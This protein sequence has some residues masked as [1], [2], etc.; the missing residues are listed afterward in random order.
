MIRCS[1]R[2]PYEPTPEPDLCQPNPCGPNGIC[3]ASVAGSFVCSCAPGY[4]GTPCRPECI[5]PTDCP[6]N[7]D[8]RNQKC[9][10]PC[11]GTCGLD[12]ICSVIGH[13][14]ICR[15]RDG[16]TGDPF[17]RCYV[18][19]LPPVTKDD[20]CNPS[21]C[22]PNSQCRVES[23]R[24]VCTCLPN[25][26]GG[27]PNC[28]P[29]CVVNSQCSSSLACIN[30]KC[31][32]PCADT[33]GDR[34]QC[35]VQNHKAICTCPPYLTG[36]AYL[37]C[38]EIPVTRPP[39]VLPA[40]DPCSGNP[41]G[42][43]SRCQAYRS[44]RVCSCL[45][46]Y[47]GTPPQC[48]PEC[49]RAEE[50]SPT[51][52][53]LV[54][55]CVD[56]CPGICGVNAEC[57][58]VSHNPICSCI[59]GYT[60]DPFV[61]CTEIPPIALTPRPTTPVPPVPAFTKPTT[62]S[63][64]GEHKEIT[65]ETIIPGKISTTTSSPIAET[66]FLEEP[67]P[68]DPCDPSPCAA[69]AACAIGYDGK[70]TCECKEG[71]F[72][73]PFVICG[74][75]CVIDSDCDRGF[76]CIQRE[77]KDPCPGACGS[78]AVCTVAG[79]RP[80]CSCIPGFSGDPY[81]EC[82]IPPI[83]KTTTARPLQPITEIPRPC[84]PNPCGANAE[85]IPVG[86]GQC[87][88]IKGYFGNPYD[89]CQPEC[90]AD[91]H[92]PYNRECRNEKCVDPCP[93]TCGLKAV[94][95]VVTHK[96]MCTCTRGYSGDP[97]RECRIEPITTERPVD[98]CNPSP[99]GPNSHCQVSYTGGHD[100]TCLPDY[101]GSP[102]DCR[103]QCVVS[104]DCPNDKACIKQKCR[105]PCPGVCGV[106]ALCEVRDH[107]PICFCPKHLTGDPFTR[108]VP[109]K[110]PVISSTSRPPI[111][112]TPSQP[113]AI[114]PETTSSTSS[115]P[116]TRE[117]TDP[118][119]NNPC[120]ERAQCVPDGSYFDC[121]CPEGMYGN[122][123]TRCKPDCVIDTDCPRNQ[124][125][126]NERCVDPCMEACGSGASCL[127]IMH[128]PV[129]TCSFGLSGD[130]Y[131]ACRAITSTTPPP[132]SETSPPES[133]PSVTPQTKFCAR[134]SCG[135]NAICK[136]HSGEVICEC[137]PAYP[138]GDP[139]EACNPQ[140]RSNDD[141]SRVESC[142][143]G[144]C[145]DPC[146]GTCGLAA[147]CT[148][149]N[150]KALCDCPQGFTGSPYRQCLPITAPPDEKDDKPCSME[151]CG[152]H[153][154]CQEENLG[155]VCKCMSGFIGSPPNCKP[156]CLN[157]DDCSRNTACINHLCS[158]PCPNACG[159]AA[160]CE[161][162]GSS[163]RCFCPPGLTGNPL[164][165]CANITSPAV[166][167]PCQCG[168]NA[169]CEALNGHTKCTCYPG[170]FG[171]PYTGCEPECVIDQDCP[172]YLACRNNKCIDPCPGYCGISA[173]CDVINHTP[174]CTCPEGF[175]GDPLNRCVRAELSPPA[176]V[177]PCTPNPCG[178]YTLCQVSGSRPVCSCM[179]GYLG[180]P[181]AG[182]KP[183]CVDNSECPPH[184]A[185]INRQCADPCEGSCAPSAECKVNKHHPLCSC[186]PGYTG[187]PFTGCALAPVADIDPCNPD[188]CGINALCHV[189]GTTDY[190]CKCPPNY[191]GN[192]FIEC[193]PEC[194]ANS[195]C[196][197]YLQCIN[198]KCEDPCPGTCGFN[199]LCETVNHYPMCDCPRGLEGD[200]K[201]ACR[202]RVAAA[203]RPSPATDAPLSAVS[204]EYDYT[205]PT[206]PL[207]T[208]IYTLC[209]SNDNCP[210]S[211]TCVNRL[212]VDI[213]RAG[214]CGIEAECRTLASRPV[215]SCPP[216]TVGNPTVQCK[217]ISKEV[218][219]VPIAQTTDRPY[220]FEINP[221]R[222]STSMRPPPIV[223]ATTTH[224]SVPIYQ[225]PITPILPTIIIACEDNDECPSDNSCVNRNCYDVCSLGVCGE[226]AECA[227]Y[228][229]R[230]VCT[231][232]LGTTVPPI[233][234]ACENNDNCHEGMSCVNLLCYDACALGVCGDHALCVASQH[235]PVCICPPGTTGNPQI[236]CLALSTDVPPTFEPIAEMTTSKT[237][238]SVKPVKGS[239]DP[240]L[241]L[242]EESKYLEPVKE[243]Y[244]EFESP[245][246]PILTVGCKNNDDC[247][248]DKSCINKICSD[249]CSQSLCAREAEC[250]TVKRRPVCTCPTGTT[251]NP[252][253][254]C[255]AINTEKTTSILVETEPTLEIQ[256]NIIKPIKIDPTLPLPIPDLSI[257]TTEKMLENTVATPPEPL[258]SIA[259]E[260]NDG[261]ATDN[262]CI[263]RLCYDVCT[264][265]ICGN[266]AECTVYDHR[267]VC[268]CPPGTTGDPLHHCLAVTVEIN[269]VEPPLVGS[270]SRPLLPV[271]PI[272]VS[273][274]FPTPIGI[275]AHYEPHEP[276]TVEKTPTPPTPDL[277]AI[278]CTTNDDC[279][280]KDT[281]LNQLCMD[282]CYPGL[283]GQNADCVTHRHKPLCKCPPGTTGNPTLKCSAL[284]TD[285]PDD[286]HPPL[287]EIPSQ[288]PED[289]IIPQ[290]GTS[291][292][293]LPPIIEFPEPHLPL[294]TPIYVS[295]IPTPTI[296]IACTNN[297]NCRGTD[298]CIN[299]MCYDACA[300]GV[301]GVN[302]N[303]QVASHRPVCHCPPGTEG[304]PQISCS[305]T[306]SKTAVTVPPIS[307][308]TSIED[309]VIVPVQG[310]ASARPK[311]I[312]QSEISVLEEP[313]YTTPV[314]PIPPT[315]LVGCENN[316]DCPSDTSCMNFVC[317]NACAQDLCGQTATCST[318]NNLP[319]CSCPPGTTGNPTKK[320]FA[321]TTESS[322][323]EPPVADVFQEQK[324]IN[325]VPQKDSSTTLRPIAVTSRP[326]DKGFKQPSLL[327]PIIPPIPVFCENNDDC[328][329]D[330]SCINELCYDVCTLGICGEDSE[331]TVFNHRPVCVCPAGTSGDPLDRC[332]AIT[333]EKI[334]PLPPLSDQVTSIH[335]ENILPITE[336]SRLPPPIG[337]PSHPKP[338][339]PAKYDVPDITIE[340]E[341]IVIGCSVND[342]CPM[343]DTCINKFCMD[344]CHPDLCGYNAECITQHH[345]PTCECPPGTTGNPTV[346]CSALATDM[347]E[348]LLPPLSESSSKPIDAPV[349][350]LVGTSSST[351]PPIGEFPEQHL[352]SPEIPFHSPEISMPPIVIAC[353]NNDD[354]IGT[355]SCVNKMC[356]NACSLGICGVNADCQ[357]D[358]HRPVCHCPKGTK[359]HPQHGCY[360][361]VSNISVSLQPIVS[362]IKIEDKII[363]PIRGEV[364]P[365]PKPIVQI[366]HKEP[367]DEPLYTLP[368]IPSPSILVGCEKG[369]DCN[370]QKSCINYVCS[371]AC[372]QTLCGENADCIT[373]KH[374]PSCSC[375]SGTTGNPTV[376][377]VAL[378][379]VEVELQSPNPAAPPKII[380][381]D[382]IAVTVMT[383]TSN[384]LTE[385]PY[386][387]QNEQEFIPPVL[388]V[389]VPLYPVS[390][391][392]NDD[393]PMDNSCINTICH[394]VCS[395]GICGTDADC[396]VTV[397]RPVC[398][399]PEG[400][401]GD[402]LKRC[403]AILTKSPSTMSP[404]YES[405]PTYTDSPLHPLSVT[406]EEIKPIGI[407]SHS[408]PSDL[409]FD[410]P[411]IP[412]SP[413]YSVGR[414]HSK[415]ST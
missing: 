148:V 389:I 31:Q 192:P 180:T 146:A 263:N 75:H 350:P 365:P 370:S 117:P 34:A 332:F 356:F 412:E 269:S 361:T 114:T 357:I 347:P 16:F 71:Y 38:V 230:P 326:I 64:I 318:S 344:I 279:P 203:D 226:S 235:R 407:P 58:V 158:D 193:G 286:P 165:A 14:P 32:N 100:C 244:H 254:K 82:L 121:I 362:T 304:D 213:C 183:G 101:F 290:M 202:K 46:G 27:P 92:C 327:L 372:T 131:V 325:I 90:T 52:A 305:A 408:Q 205:R 291:S 323:R 104:K 79:H 220:I 265:S 282:I 297:D 199:A 179:T 6:M 237:I 156:E 5:L 187:D 352:P 66:P 341:P 411:K 8:C 40:P 128:K 125:C 225:T 150:H 373:H 342:D 232:P 21:P 28:H 170:Y 328:S 35:A 309:S 253:I 144:V 201:V 381:E 321:L 41:C 214:V 219:T 107:N 12:A 377:C 310:V 364:F 329:T 172:K 241:P 99:C 85:C 37:R 376:K 97:Y 363:Q 316:D 308:S 161:A 371:D 261:C 45:P 404:L 133:Y 359:G 257:P 190:D 42:P 94:C 139:K 189:I 358:R 260:N 173:L 276:V 228:D 296:T 236:K 223:S 314:I 110:D 198:L 48:R 63:P 395:L 339:E 164:V 61:R 322:E 159:F 137:P 136:D 221:I 401:T 388:P 135:V 70:P 242:K 367:T 246:L 178:V 233:A 200:P 176:T 289:L 88:C 398:S 9:V 209:E 247:S 105:D 255:V 270:T 36:D 249:L 207:P 119:E 47:K 163:P 126:K 348:E 266:N 95:Q 337:I 240:I 206:T 293:P 303:C 393:C 7:E 402:P 243:T 57:F 294:E 317:T 83:S 387:G 267:P 124:A 374:R 185:C 184:E 171:N 375:P 283:C 149:Q 256:E 142:V 315:I 29:E 132:S 93:G 250:I 30:R 391:A 292:T 413:S 152:P 160:Q 162:E 140:C 210:D 166:E 264:L 215:C 174:M 2:P 3:T 188:P 65:D 43:N 272:T 345:K 299:M 298:S 258:L 186:P 281:C 39:I 62:L 195:D 91:S 336:T 141:C 168:P 277:I 33:C 151:E 120:G 208:K 382:I 69:N 262:S 306:A 1:D 98:P 53:C 271:L 80:K 227:V 86:S 390:C 349:I 409:A 405:T 134:D 22:G 353:I 51:K 400:F 234:V 386:F 251:G 216:G 410:Q 338:H 346:K 78:N 106:E 74:P 252:T 81:V 355:D 396:K 59:H 112:V 123:Y 191:F 116:V 335:E 177:D 288:P 248:T 312:A 320:C 392:N 15:C 218:P 295:K 354:C 73:N 211:S 56:P 167:H 245:K 20:P 204:S 111:A 366:S 109:F 103:P 13:A 19:A 222:G 122:P 169:E 331:C 324:V 49:V 4:L 333:T 138:E 212:C 153:A 330:N 60:G 415:R 307:L 239:Q 231:C 313:L 217:A 54:N 181:D 127:A 194:T 157:N 77:C 17:S 68:Y 175:T 380:S 378:N 182:C 280:L 96:P 379:V 278:G 229:H 406:T 10:D 268:K 403:M 23:G 340:Q 274:E 394:D 26:Y 287:S 115:A 154:T 273:T 113:P 360:A 384:P 72:G 108:C 319:T 275:P 285:I 259:C 147:R 197:R 368:V 284:A 76:A 145:T 11:P 334:S 87:Q 397:H 84:E 102:P 155:S 25:F 385:F 129:C 55:K 311:P 44:E 224:S 369:N 50:C 301:C 302:A 300:L 343:K 67:K 118:C 143:N 130:P 196:P 18:E 383:P 238:H 89:V 399:C 24:P 414:R 351:L